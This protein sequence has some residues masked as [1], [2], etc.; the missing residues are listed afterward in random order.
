[1]R[2][3][4]SSNT[5]FQA[6]AHAWQVQSEPAAEAPQPP[7][8]AGPS[9]TSTPVGLGPWS[10][11]RRGTGHHARRHCST[12][13]QHRIDVAVELIQARGFE[14]VLTEL[15]FLKFD[16]RRYHIN[17]EGTRWSG[18]AGELGYT[19]AVVSAAAMPA[20][21]FTLAA[22]RIG[23]GPAEYWPRLS[24]ER[25]LGPSLSTYSGTL[26]RLPAPRG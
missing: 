3:Q 16:R 19:L 22:R 26:K 5:Q 15:P 4:L 8:Q 11:I 23:A 18:E 17:R 24:R 2:K 13:G 12:R 7:G 10:A 1:M 21:F 20:H 25:H 14:H 6:E 9:P